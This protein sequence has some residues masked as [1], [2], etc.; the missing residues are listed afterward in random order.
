MR[1]FNFACTGF[2]LFLRLECSSRTLLNGTHKN[3]SVSVVATTKRS[4]DKIVVSRA[5]W[6]VIA[7]VTKTKGSFQKV[8][9]KAVQEIITTIQTAWKIIVLRFPT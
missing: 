5:K 6:K 4:T 2:R 9:G 1:R 8:N 3:K 7:C